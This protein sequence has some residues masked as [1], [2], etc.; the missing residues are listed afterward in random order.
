MVLPSILRPVNCSRPHAGEA[1]GV[2]ETESKHVT[3]AQLNAS[4]VKLARRLTRMPDPTVGGQLTV[5][6]G[7][8]HVDSQGQEQLGFSTS[9]G[10]GGWA[11]CLLLTPEVH[12]LKGA[13]LG[14]GTRPVPWS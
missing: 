8:L 10:E 11:M 13:L 12:P 2:T 7:A 3:Q 4:C 9:A 1:F 14:L 6:V 5:R